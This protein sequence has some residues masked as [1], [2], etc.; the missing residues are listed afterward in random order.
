MNVA[1]KLVKVVN[2][3]NVIRFM[4]AIHTSSW[5]HLPPKRAARKWIRQWFKWQTGSIYVPLYTA[6]LLR[7]CRL[8]HLFISASYSRLESVHINCIW[9][10]CLLCSNHS[11]ERL[12]LHFM[13]DSRVNDAVCVCI[14]I[15]ANRIDL[16]MCTPFVQHAKFCLHSENGQG[17]YQKWQ[18][19]LLAPLLS[20]R[21][22]IGA[23]I[24]CWFLWFLNAIFPFACNRTVNLTKIYRRFIETIESVLLREFVGMQ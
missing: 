15:I 13:V 2:L 20:P 18:V 9:R 4:S 3:W 17:D 11:I 14:L 6:Q 7:E 1:S 10:C 5:R 23:S 8:S 16:K 22:F 21:Y 12:Q 19:C 24:E